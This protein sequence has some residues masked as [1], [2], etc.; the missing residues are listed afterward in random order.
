MLVG[1]SVCVAV[2]VSVGVAVD[3]SVGVAVAVSV[4]VGVCVGVR[5]G[6]RV[7]VHVAAGDSTANKATCAAMPSVAVPSYVAVIPLIGASFEN[8]TPR[9]SIMALWLRSSGSFPSRT[10]DCPMVETSGA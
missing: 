7:G 1:V 10:S 6:V 8:G 5:V 3:V 2:G 9:D 4:G